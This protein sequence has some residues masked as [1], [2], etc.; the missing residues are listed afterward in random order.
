MGST[1][2]VQRSIQAVRVESSAHEVGDSTKPVLMGWEVPRDGSCARTIVVTV[3]V[4]RS[5]R[6][7][8]WPGISDAQAGSGQRASCRGHSLLRRAG[9]EGGGSVTCDSGRKTFRRKIL[10]GGGGDEE[11]SGETPSS[12]GCS[13]ASAVGWPGCREVSK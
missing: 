13:V 4:N 1:G 10:D 7:Y 11:E 12:R 3:A 6:E 5:G 8:L 2:S 9:M